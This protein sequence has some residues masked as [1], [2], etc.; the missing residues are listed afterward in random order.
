MRP[1]SE[2]DPSKPALVHDRLSDRTFVW[3]PHMAKIYRQYAA[4]HAPGVIEFDGLGWPK[5]KKPPIAEAI[6]Q[7]PLLCGPDFAENSSN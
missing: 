7:C 3:A 2:F 6:P 4:P 5:S 1:M